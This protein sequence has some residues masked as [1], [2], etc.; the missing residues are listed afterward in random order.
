MFLNNKRKGRDINGV[1]MRISAILEMLS[2]IDDELIGK[3]L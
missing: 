3:F 1:F 2:N